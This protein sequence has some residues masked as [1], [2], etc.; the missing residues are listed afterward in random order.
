MR[1]RNKVKIMVQKY[2]IY[3]LTDL[4]GNKWNV[5]EVLESMTENEI[6]TVCI[7]YGID[8]VKVKQ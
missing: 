3:T 2:E 8:E 7:E 4:F 6:D 1:G 5:M